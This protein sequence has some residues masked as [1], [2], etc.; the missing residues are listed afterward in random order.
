MGDSMSNEEID[1]KK[2]VIK[3]ITIIKKRAV[4]IIAFIVVFNAIAVYKV[5]VPEYK[6]MSS[7][8]I[9]VNTNVNTNANEQTE[10][11][12]S[13]VDLGL[14]V[15]GI[16][17]THVDNMNVNELVNLLEIKEEYVRSII[18][19]LVKPV[20]IKTPSFSVEINYLGDNYSYEFVQAIVRYLNEE[21]FAKTHQN[22]LRKSDSLMYLQLID[23]LDKIDKD[24][25]LKSSDI[26]S[27]DKE[28]LYTHRLDLL[29]EK[30]K[31]ELNNELPNIFYLGNS[32]NGVT[33]KVE[34]KKDFAKLFLFSVLL[35]IVI[36]SLIEL[37]IFIRKVY[38]EHQN[39][40]K[41]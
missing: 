32:D 8:I 25:A 15:S 41:I 4:V 5:N 29:K 7:Y 11:T 35:T 33:L 27:K 12:Q 6:K 21:T 1:V 38:D 10:I 28:A 20:T 26:K 31:I 37:I 19:L 14:E 40:N 22:A 39:T 16:L 18:D 13:M 17:S 2:L 30:Q 3:I 9:L 23:D 36:I 34:K 24:L